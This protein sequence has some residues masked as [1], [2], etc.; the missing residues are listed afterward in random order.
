MT[1]RTLLLAS[2]VLLTVPTGA[3]AAHLTTPVAS[4]TSTQCWE[5]GSCR[6]VEVGS[7]IFH[8]GPGVYGLM[9]TVRRMEP[10]GYFSCETRRDNVKVYSFHCHFD[11][12]RN[13]YSRVTATYHYKTQ[14]MNYR[15]VTY[16]CNQGTCL[17]NTP[18]G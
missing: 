5:D 14:R 3:Q 15:F 8:Y 18:A 6:L 10:D 4:S 7:R 17:D 12:D 11:I 16:S 13:N 1:R 2:L 9:R